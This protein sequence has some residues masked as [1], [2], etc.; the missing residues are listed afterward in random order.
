[1]GEEIEHPQGTV[2]KTAPQYVKNTLQDQSKV[3]GLQ[4]P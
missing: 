2:G 1:M 3:F 4:K